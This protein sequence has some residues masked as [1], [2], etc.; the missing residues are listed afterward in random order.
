VP[1]GVEVFD[2]HVHI[3]PPNLFEAL[4]RWFEKHAWSVRYRL[5]AEEVVEF[6]AGRGV[7][8][9]TALHYSHSPGLAPILNRFAAEIARAHPQVV[10]LGT[11][12]PGEPDAAAIVR[13]A[14]ALGL[15]GLKLHCHVQRIAPDDERLD[16]VYRACADARLPVVI[17][18]GRQPALPAYALDIAALCSVDRIARVLERHP[19]LT[20][21]VPHLGIDEIAGYAALLDRHENLWLDTTMAI[22]RYFPVPEAPGIL[23]AR[24]NRILY[25]TDFPNIP[26][27]W[28]RELKVLFEEGLTDE[29]RRAI[30][31]DNAAR[32]FGG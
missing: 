28:D 5:H 10:A 9:F 16:E 23:R 14:F 2:A 31:W 24:W 8:R 21:V 20:L 3:F 1:A 27:S 19:R 6:L 18:A 17:H 15:R 30:L 25:G 7:R 22:G 26:Y 12:L 32:V 13:E 11:V 4:W 29:Q